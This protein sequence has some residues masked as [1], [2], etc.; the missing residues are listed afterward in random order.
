MILMILLIKMDHK[1][2]CQSTCGTRGLSGH[3]YLVPVDVVPKAQEHL[4]EKLYAEI[5]HTPRLYSGN[6]LDIFSR[7]GPPKQLRKAEPVCAQRETENNV[8]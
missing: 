2:S 1:I 7:S 4:G 6:L 5:V 3:P 8:Q